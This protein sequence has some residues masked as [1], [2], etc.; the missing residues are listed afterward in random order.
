MALDGVQLWAF[1]NTA[2]ALGIYKSWRSGVLDQA[3]GSSKG[4]CSVE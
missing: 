2:M 3:S 1:V 4:F